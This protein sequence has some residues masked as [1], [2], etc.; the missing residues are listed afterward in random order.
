MTDSLTFKNLGILFTFYSIVYVF[1]Y[2]GFYGIN[3]FY[4]TDLQGV[5]TLFLSNTIKIIIFSS[6]VLLIVAGISKKSFQVKNETFNKL[7]LRRTIILFYIL[8]IIFIGLFIMLLLGIDSRIN[9]P[10]FSITAFAVIG[11]LH[12]IDRLSKLIRYKFK[13]SAYNLK[14][15]FSIILIVPYFMCQLIISEVNY[16]PKS[17][18]LYF[19]Y[20]ESK[21]VETGEKFKLYLIGKTNENIFIYDKSKNQTLIFEMS[22]VKDFKIYDVPAPNLYPK[23]GAV[24]PDKGP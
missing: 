13:I 5:L 21:T 3:I 24:I 7:S 18:H 4:Y 2:Y 14:A 12:A 8:F 17:D 9:R 1:V 22:N 6:L 23:A 19:C 15:Y 10:L 11:I 20:N 16:F